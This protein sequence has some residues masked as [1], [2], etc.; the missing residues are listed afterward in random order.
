[1]QARHQDE[2]RRL[3]LD[4]DG[5][6]AAVEEQAAPALHGRPV[7]VLP[8]EGARTCVISANAAA[9]RHGV[10]TGTG[11]DEARRRCP[12]IALV[13][14]RPDLYVRVQ[15]RIAHAVNA[16]LPIDAVCSVDELCCV[17]GARDG[18]QDVGRR[19]KARLRDAVGPRVTCSMGVAP[20]RWLAK[21]ASAMDKPDGLTVLDALP[22]R[23]LALDLED[24]PGVGARVRERL[25]RAGI[26]TVAALWEARPKALRA[27]WGSVHGERLWYALHGH[28]VGPL[29]TRRGSIGHGR[30]LPPEARSAATA[31]PWVRLLMVKAA[32][33]LRREGWTARRLGL[34]VERIGAPPWQGAAALDRVDDDR[35]CLAALGACGMRS[36]RTGPGPASSGCR[37]GLTAWRRSRAGRGSCSRDRVRGGRRRRR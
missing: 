8:Y 32:R 31:R 2:R 4:F 7:A 20:N 24:L 1:M 13:G 5:Y 17:L 21:V 25:R 6:F 10:G 11:V 35:A 15:R 28:D 19:I 27:V 14:Q 9:K 12:G 16:E 33:R 37:C 29:R 30:V 18:A 3:Y 36:R 22:G 34:A 23:L 26:D